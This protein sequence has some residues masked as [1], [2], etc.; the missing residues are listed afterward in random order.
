MSETHDED[1]L[2]RF[3]HLEDGASGALK[4]GPDYARGELLLE[5][6]DDEGDKNDKDASEDSDDSGQHEGIIKLGDGSK[7]SRVAEVNLDESDFADLDAQALAYSRS[8]PADDEQN[9]KEQAQRTSRL[10]VVNLDWEHVR[11]THL[12]K[13]SSSLVSLTAPLLS[14]SETAEGNGMGKGSGHTVARGRVLNVRIYPSQFGKERMAREEKEGPPAEIF[15]KRKDDDEEVNEKNIYDVGDEADYDEDALRNYQ[16]E[17]LRYLISCCVIAHPFT[18]QR[19][20][21]AIITCNTV[22]AATHIYS[23]LEGT[24]L[25]RSANVFDMSFVPDD[26]VFD[27]EFRCASSSNGLI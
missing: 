14:A 23:E 11:A 17:R 18:Y 13:I 19:Y 9:N 20:Y 5:S 3:Y 16:L 12:Y 26:M 22:D 1:N 7:T 2:K 21:Y 10:A 15:K 8:H 4:P 24:E 25:E 6:S 27:D